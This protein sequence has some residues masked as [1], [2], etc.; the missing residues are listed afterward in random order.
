MQTKVRID[1][2][3][4]LTRSPALVVTCIRTVKTTTWFEEHLTED[5]QEFMKKSMA[6]EY[7]RQTADKLNPLKD[8]PW[9]RH[10]WTEGGSLAASVQELRL[11]MGL[12]FIPPPHP[13]VSWR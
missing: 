2:F 1:A 8:E 10:Q 13:P 7:G 4:L 12:I 11:Q 6:E 3:L 5:N 9:L